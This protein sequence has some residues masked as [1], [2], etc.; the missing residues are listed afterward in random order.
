MT[1]ALLGA[2]TCRRVR[3]TPRPRRRRTAH[4]AR[5]GALRRPARRS[6]A[7]LRAVPEAAPR[8]EFVAD[9]R[10]RLMAEADT[11]AR[12]AARRRRRASRC[13]HHPHPRAP[14]RRARSAALAL[15]GATTTDGRR[16]PDRAARRVA[17]PDQAGHRVRPG[18]LRRR[19]R[20]TG[21]TLL[22]SADT[23]LDEVER[24]RGGRRRQHHAHPRHPR[25]PSPTRP[26]TASD[27]LLGDYDRSGRDVDRPACRDFTAAAAWSAST[28]CRPQLPAER[29]RRAARAPA[30]RSADLDQRD[31]Q[32]LPR[33]APAGS[34][35]CR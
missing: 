22:A 28:P 3:G 10:E 17:L 20:R 2:T 6:S 13:P 16:R 23:R 27:L 12:S 8:A 5:C 7:D 19:R 33:R 9:L 32:R 4:R 30:A 18:R 1:A 25:R 11:V 15:V 31:Q 21:S 35:R 24:A 34:P 14:R 26:A 29:P